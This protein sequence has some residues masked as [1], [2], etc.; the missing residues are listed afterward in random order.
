MTEAAP[1]LLSIIT[2]TRQ[3]GQL[4][5]RKLGALR[6]QNLQP[7]LFEWV[8][9]FD[10]GDAEARAVLEHALDGEP[11]GFAVRITETVARV[12]P[13]VARNRA[14]ELASGRILLLSDDD[15]LPAP[16]CL[17]LHVQ[18]Q[19]QPAVYVG[20]IRFEGAAPGG[21]WR[22]A[23]VGW[24]NVNGANTSVP[25]ANFRHVGGFPDY[26]EGYGCEDVALGW[27]LQRDGL[28]PVALPAATVTHVG[29]AAGREG[30]PSRWREAGANAARLAQR[31]PEMAA[32]L[33]VQG[34]QG[35]LKRLAI[36]FMGRRGRLEA[37]YLEGAAE[38]RRKE[39]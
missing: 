37:A 4:L 18:A 22:P 13:G 17:S 9:C 34:W 25:A 35:L 24:W 8:L 19:A 11:P 12:G 14:A 39:R 23:S 15:C 26:L 27:L 16:D 29:P 21:D 2:P 5:L 7:E 32:R 3:R 6:E 28:S 20:A 31:H 36:P 1:P 38:V 30:P 10:G 33:G